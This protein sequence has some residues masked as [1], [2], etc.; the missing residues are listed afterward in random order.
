MLLAI[1]TT[2]AWV[3][4]ALHGPEG[5]VA[6]S[7]ALAAM[8]HSQRSVAEVDHVL[9][10]AGLRPPDLGGIAVALGP[11]SFTGLRVGLSVAKGLGLA[12]GRPV[13]GV[14]S[15]LAM[16]WPYR[17]LA[18]ER[19]LG[20]LLDLGRG[21]LAAQWYSGRSLRLVGELV[22]G[23]LARVVANAPVGP[24]LVVAAAGAAASADLAAVLGSR[25]VFTAT[26]APL[27]RIAGLAAL[28]WARLARGEADD[29]A[30][31]QPLYPQRSGQPTDRVR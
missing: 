12:L 17:E 8:R 24:L 31:L 6:A 4:V 1:D 13:L 29:L 14:G 10:R 27:V 19:A 26:P 30:T 18:E 22:V 3:G 15:L 11:G 28:G 21:E 23:D 16:A 5:L 7:S 2:S 20:V 9:A 25:A